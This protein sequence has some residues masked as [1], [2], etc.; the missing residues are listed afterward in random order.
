M[1]KAVEKILNT[2]SSMRKAYMDSHNGDDPKY[3]MVGHKVYRTLMIYIED[4]KISCYLHLDNKGNLNLFGA[5]VI[6]CSYFSSQGIDIIE[7]GY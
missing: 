1:D 3:F 5:E 2:V 6:P 4:N 7:R